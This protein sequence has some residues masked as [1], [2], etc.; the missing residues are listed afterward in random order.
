MIFIQD[1]HLIIL[2]GLKFEA[3]NLANMLHLGQKPSDICDIPN[4]STYLTY[5]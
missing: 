2:I 3:C 4:M 5:V 1:I